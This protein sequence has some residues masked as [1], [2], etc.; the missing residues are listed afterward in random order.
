[1]LEALE[2]ADLHEE[3]SAF[4]ETLGEYF[5][6]TEPRRGAATPQ[7]IRLGTPANWLIKRLQLEKRDG[8]DPQSTDTLITQAI[9]HLRLRWS[10]LCVDYAQLKVSVASKR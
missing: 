9:D 7:D 3:E 2:K 8:G 5:M 4:L 6:Y 10:D 1:M